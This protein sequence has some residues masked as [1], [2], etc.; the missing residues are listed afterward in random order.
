MGSKPYVSYMKTIAI[1]AQT[2]Y[3]YI[4]ISTLPE[5]YFSIG[6]GGVLGKITK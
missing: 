5:P 1:T 4:G 3:F 2:L 6:M